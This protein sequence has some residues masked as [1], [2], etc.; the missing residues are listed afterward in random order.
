[1]E[2]LQSQLRAPVPEV[3]TTASQFHDAEER[4]RPNTEKAAAMN[5]PFETIRGW[6][7]R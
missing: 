6:G 4:K 1:M 7:L 5:D 2:A 3:T